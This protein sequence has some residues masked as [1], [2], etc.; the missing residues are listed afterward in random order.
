[1]RV[2]V[3]LPRW[4]GDVVMAEPTLRALH[5]RFGAD[6]TL[7]GS[8]P[9]V[10]LVARGLPGAQ[11]VVCGRRPEVAPWRGHDVALLLDGS[12]ASAWTALRAG[13]PRRVGFA[14]GGRG[15]LLTDGLTPP[16][17]RG[18]VPLGL[19]RAGRWPRRL[20]RPFGASCVELAGRLGV[21][22]AARQPRLEVDEAQLQRARA[23][24]APGPYLVV[25]AGARPGSAKGYGGARWGQVLEVLRARG[26]DLPIYLLAGPGEEQA[27]REAATVPGAT[28]VVDPVADLGELAAWCAEAELVVGTDG[29]TR[30]VAHAVGAARV[31]LFG[32]TD[33]RHTTET[34]VGEVA[35]RDEVPCGPCHRERCPLPTLVCQEQLTPERV[36][37]AVLYS[38]RSSSRT[39]MLR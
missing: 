27:A 11:R 31:T 5:A 22:V 18:R 38:L 15:P 35:L 32:P 21:T 30:H 16:A 19:G 28:A 13:V 23:R 1:M 4:L 3:R 2:L 25:Q 8:G 26:L 39:Q 7:A 34:L 17:E 14:G 6:L 36:A 24:R 10:D 12:L 9:L 33:P 29:G 37:D 20:P